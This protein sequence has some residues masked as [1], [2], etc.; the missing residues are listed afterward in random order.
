MTSTK[1][2]T[3]LERLIQQRQQERL[4]LASGAIFQTIFDQIE[5]ISDVA[6][7]M[8]LNI[9]VATVRNAIAELLKDGLIESDF[10]GL[11]SVAF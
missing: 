4:L 2:K 1:T 8:D 5:P 11:W 3:H 6:I 10:Q 7:A 9:S